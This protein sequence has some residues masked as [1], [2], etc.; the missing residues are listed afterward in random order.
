[1]SVMSLGVS[2]LIGP[3]E[4]LVNESRLLA[5]DTF[6]PFCC[7]RP[8]CAAAA[9]VLVGLA[10]TPGLLKRAL[11]ARCLSLDVS[12]VGGVWPRAISSAVFSGLPA[13]EVLHRNRSS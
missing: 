12:R 1:M 9:V 10:V 7:S 8:L 2:G 13:L 11:G 4:R 5:A 3:V 6:F